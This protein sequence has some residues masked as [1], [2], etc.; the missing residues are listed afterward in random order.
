MREDLANHDGLY[1]LPFG[2]KC[3]YTQR[4]KLGTRLGI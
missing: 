3:R 1:A 2:Q 4:D